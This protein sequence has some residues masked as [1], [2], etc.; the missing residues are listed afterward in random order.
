[1]DST[2][3]AG[4]GGHQPFVAVLAPGWLDHFIFNEYYKTEEEFL[5][6]RGLSV[7]A[8]SA[9]AASAAPAAAEARKGPARPPRRS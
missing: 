4:T 2:R 8:A 7:S 9:L 1:L 6:A 5:F 3:V